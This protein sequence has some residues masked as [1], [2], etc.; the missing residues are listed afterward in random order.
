MPCHHGTRLQ[1]QPKMADTSSWPVTH[2]DQVDPGS[3]SFVG[4]TDTNIPASQD[5]SQLTLDL[6]KEFD[7]IRPEL[8]QIASHGLRKAFRL[9]HHP[10]WVIYPPNQLPRHMQP[11]TTLRKIGQGGLGAV[12][13]HPDQNTVLKREFNAG[14]DSD[15]MQREHHMHHGVYEAML[16][17]NHVASFFVNVQVPRDGAFISA[18]SCDWDDG[19]QFFFPDKEM[20]CRSDM[21]Q[22][23]RIPAVSEDI[24]LDIIFKYCSDSGI[25]PSMAA[26][27]EASDCL[28]RIYLGRESSVSEPF[29]MQNFPLHI[30]QLEALSINTL[31]IAAQLGRALAIIHFQADI[32]GRGVEFV[33]GG[34]RDQRDETQIWV[35]DFNQCQPLQVSRFGDVT[36]QTM[37]DSTG[38]VRPPSAS[39]VQRTDSCID[40]FFEN[41]PYFP[42]PDPKRPDLWNTFARNYDYMTREITIRS[43]TSAENRV[44][45]NFVRYRPST[46]EEF[47]VLT[48]CPKPEDGQ[49]GTY[50][51]IT[52]AA[53][54]FLWG[55]EERHLK[56]TKS[57]KEAAEF[58]LGL[59]SS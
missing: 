53:S 55:I 38:S 27:P 35:L 24:R 58:R 43:W 57:C 26:S 54:L 4:I 19:L 31:K 30:D 49:I 8:A 28:I 44:C 22:A 47:E 45:Y 42:R 59:V 37:I 18:T 41:D 29:H 7:E 52:R 25:W 2:Q 15:A 6:V 23:E 34:A 11:Q 17:W 5:A 13:A 32:D 21:I 20:Q 50:Q 14:A 39:D 46:A 56:G 16:K 40:A 12:Y 51:P 48:M 10:V 1:A 3:N 9:R 33:L 36:Q